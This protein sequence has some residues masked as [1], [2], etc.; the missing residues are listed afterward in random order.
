M[1]R[2]HVSISL[3]KRESVAK[4]QNTK[5]VFLESDIKVG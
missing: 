5:T 4:I 1:E 3:S 2:N